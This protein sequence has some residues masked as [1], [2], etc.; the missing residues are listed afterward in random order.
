MSGEGNFITAEED[1]VAANRLHA[2]QLWNRRAI[3][4]GWILATV[5]LALVAIGVCER[6]NWTMLWVPVASATLMVIGAGVSQLTFSQA[7]RRH[8]RQAHAFWRPTTIEW[9]DT[10]VG[11]AT[12]RG[13]VRFQWTDFFSWAAD[14]RSVLL[15]QSANSFITIPIKKLDQQAKV[16]IA[17]ALKNVGVPERSSR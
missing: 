15:Y 2:R 8:F 14:D 13:K 9:D 17:S 6:L 1:V 16:E 5:A 3:L 7:A 4:R 10:S 12:D 11:F